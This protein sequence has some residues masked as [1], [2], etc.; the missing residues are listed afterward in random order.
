MAKIVSLANIDLPYQV[1]QKDLEQYAG[2]M[3]AEAF[4]DIDR[5]LPVFEN[6]SIINRNFCVPV[7][8]YAQDRS[9]KEK[10]DLFIK[11]ALEYSVQAIEKCL[12]LTN[13]TK[14]N[15]TDIVFVSTTGLSTPSIDALI[16]NKMKLD[17]NINRIPIWG[18][19]CAGGVSGLAKANALA[20]ANPDAIVL[21]VAVE[22]CSLTFIRNDLSKSNF[23]ATSLFSD[24]VSALLVAGDN[25]N[26]DSA[27]DIRIVSSESRL[28][29]D[30][31]DV[32]GWDFENEGFKVLFSRDI[33]TIVNDTVKNDIQHFL[34]KNNLT[35]DDIKNFII[36]PGG[37]KVIDA[38][39]NSLQIDRSK[40]DNTFTVL[41]NYGNMSSVTAFYV[42]DKFLTDGFDDGYGLMMSLG[43]G[44]SCEMLL[45]DMKHN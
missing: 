45:L 24:G 25:C 17:P 12:S 40:L 20:K 41:Q 15:I 5:L 13:I 43:P 18:L 33:P 29:Y 21:F 4:P 42:L 30:S 8:F 26:V 7:D 14:D 2:N 9:F 34:T 32:M 23:I 27:N 36:H 28:Y 37:M 10:N 6:T 16:I 31:L 1:S 19:G 39:V 38:Y 44:F 3:F 35:L 22:L 11:Y